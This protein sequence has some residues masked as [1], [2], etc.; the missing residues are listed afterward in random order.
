MKRPHHAGLE[1]D[2]IQEGMVGSFFEMVKP[3]AKPTGRDVIS[4]STENK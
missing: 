4:R 2:I 1:R 3:Q